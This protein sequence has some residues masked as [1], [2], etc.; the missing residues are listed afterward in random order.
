MAATD[1]STFEKLAGLGLACGRHLWPFQ[2]SISV[3]PRRADEP[4][5]H[6]FEFDSAAI[7][8]S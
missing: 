2:C 8:V 3:R 4:T 7:A 6:A 5:A 1:V